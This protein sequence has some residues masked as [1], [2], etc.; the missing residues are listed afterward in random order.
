MVDAITAPPASPAR[1]EPHVYTSDYYLS[2]CQG[3]E[4]F[5][6]SGGVACVVDGDT[7]GSLLAR[8]DAA[9]YSAK[10]A[11]RNLVFRHEGSLIEPVTGTLLAEYQPTDR[12][13]HLPSLLPL[14]ALPA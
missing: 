11:G 3:Y 2:H 12:A 8:A 7:P 5:I 4:E 9:L 6:T 10:S 1:V 14:E 13:D